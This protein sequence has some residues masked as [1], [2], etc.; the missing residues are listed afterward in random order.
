MPIDPYAAL[1]A[2]LRAEAVRNAPHPASAPVK[3]QNEDEEDHQE[4]SG[5]S[6]R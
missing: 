1:H 4:R 2:L 6:D 3:T 5:Q